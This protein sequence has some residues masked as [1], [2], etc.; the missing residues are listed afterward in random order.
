M[1]GFAFGLAVG[2]VAGIFPGAA[3]AGTEPLPG[4]PV[5][6]PRVNRPPTL[7]SKVHVVPA[8]PS[9]LHST[10]RALRIGRA[11]TIRVE[12]EDPDGDPLTYRATPLPVGATFDEQKGELTWKPRRSDEGKVELTFEV[13]DGELS[14]TQTF[15]FYVQVNRAPDAEGERHIVLVARDED[16]ERENQRNRS[17][18]SVARDADADELSLVVHQL[19]PGAKLTPTPGNVSFSWLPE[20]TA[21]GEH[22]LAFTVSDG[23][24]QTTVEKKVVVLPAW[25]RDD[26]RRWFLLGVGGSGFFR[27]AND[28]L[29]LGG[30]FDATFIMLRESGAAGYRCANGYRSSGCHASHHRF[31]AEVEVLANVSHENAPSVFVYGGGYSA[32]LEWA[33][34]RRHLIPHYGFELGGIVLPDRGHLAQTRPYLG[35]HLFA[36]DDLW[37]NAAFGYRLVPAALTEW[38][39]PSLALRAIVNPW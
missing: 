13:S 22:H 31:Y 23:E 34:L 9:L 26:Y 3:A 36:G 21:V 16:P 38:S 32:S 39:G 1:R 10:A 12:G 28:E 17:P 6:L 20:A 15:S 24:L 18:H 8:V 27:P 5:A 14:A 35:L 7:P 2:F 4:G 19:P 30:A 37:I 25:A 33:P 11:T 29:L